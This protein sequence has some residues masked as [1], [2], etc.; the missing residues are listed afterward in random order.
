M[1]LSKYSHWVSLSYHSSKVEAT[2]VPG[3]AKDQTDS[4]I[5]NKNCLAEPQ[6][7]E[8]R[9]HPP[10][11]SCNLHGHRVPSQSASYITG[12]ESGSSEHEVPA[13]EGT[14]QEME[15]ER[16]GGQGQRRRWVGWK[17]RELVG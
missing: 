2:L 14:S 11:A 8:G 15:T 16:E 12:P 4:E 10:N 17:N 6:G 9:W 5:R 7:Q 1:S 13:E 3:P